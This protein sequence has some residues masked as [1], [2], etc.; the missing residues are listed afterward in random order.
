MVREWG[1]TDETERH[2]VD[3]RHERNALV[4]GLFDEFLAV[5][6]GL[7]TGKEIVEVWSWLTLG[8]TD[9]PVAFLDLGGNWQ[10]FLT[11]VRGLVDAG[12]MA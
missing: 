8:F 6:G 2:V 7:G 11:A 3:T 1:R 5:P 4:A 10:L 12:F 9:K